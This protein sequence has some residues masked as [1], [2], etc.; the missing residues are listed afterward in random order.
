MYLSLQNKGVNREIKSVKEMGNHYR[1]LIGTCQSRVKLSTGFMD[2]LADFIA[3]SLVVSITLE[4]PYTDERY[5]DEY[6]DSGDGIS[7]PLACSL[8][9]T[10]TWHIEVMRGLV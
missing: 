10:H 6:S 3:N 2:A 5:R 7:S 1:V 8:S 9:N 4:A